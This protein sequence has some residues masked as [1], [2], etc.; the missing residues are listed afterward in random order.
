MFRSIH[1]MN[2]GK[3]DSNSV[4]AHVHCSLSGPARNSGQ[5]LEGHSWHN[6]SPVFALALVWCVHST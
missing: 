5:M 1:T 2:G 4:V 6:I 3:S